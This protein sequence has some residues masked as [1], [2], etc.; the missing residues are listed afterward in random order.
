MSACGAFESFYGL[1]HAVRP[2]EVSIPVTTGG[3]GEAGAGTYR[4]QF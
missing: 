1:P 4:S 2:G 3:A